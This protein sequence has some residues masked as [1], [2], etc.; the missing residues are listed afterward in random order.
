VVT[1]ATPC[2]RGK[3]FVIKEVNPDN[4]KLMEARI[5]GRY[6]DAILYS[7]GTTMYPARK[8]KL[9]VNWYFIA[10][11]IDNLAIAL[12]FSLLRILK[13]SAYVAVLRRKVEHDCCRSST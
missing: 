4:R 6:G 9:D 11:S 13:P 5:S 3:V 1:N 10:S 8:N 2:L 7:S 12:P